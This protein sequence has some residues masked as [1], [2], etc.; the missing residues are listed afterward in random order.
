[1]RVVVVVLLAAC[2]ASAAPQ[3]APLKNSAPL[4]VGAFT[5]SEHHFGP[6]DARTPATL[7]GLRQVLPGYDVREV[8]DGSLE[9][10][11]FDGAERLL[12]VVPNEDGS[13]FNIHATSARVHV[14][15]RDWRVGSRIYDHLDL[16]KC[17]C[18]G[19]NPTCFKAGEHVAV[20][21]KAECTGAPPAPDTIK[22]KLIQRVIWSPKPFGT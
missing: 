21:F 12:F 7:A 18:W 6:I 16:S 17:E 22:D 14:A 13:I 9:Y 20:N 19:S 2:G 11:V 10:D 1:M 3:A 15:D 8:N 4:A 5:I